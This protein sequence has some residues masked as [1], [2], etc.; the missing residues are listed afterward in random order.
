MESKKTPEV[1]TLFDEVV[2]LSLTI[3]QAK[4]KMQ[5]IEQE[6]QE[7]TRE[8]SI[9]ARELFISNLAYKNDFNNFEKRISVFLLNGDAGEEALKSKFRVLKELL[10]IY[11]KVQFITKGEKQKWKI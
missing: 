2:Y 10:E 4:A 8:S 1:I 5:E 3:K 6:T 11:R 9:M 7:M